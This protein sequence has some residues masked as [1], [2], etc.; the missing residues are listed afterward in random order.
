MMVSSA[1]G[2]TDPETA[3]NKYIDDFEPDLPF[4]FSDVGILI[5][6]PQ[7][8]LRSQMDRL[9][10]DLRSVYPNICVKVFN[11]MPGTDGD[12][13]VRVW[14]GGSGLFKQ[15]QC[16]LTSPVEGIP[17]LHLLITLSATSEAMLE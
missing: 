4:D 13:Y 7:Y 15:V 16:D 14:D 8:C 12:Y 10:G 2:V 5:N 17:L 3:D 11:T 9:A 6:L 1:G